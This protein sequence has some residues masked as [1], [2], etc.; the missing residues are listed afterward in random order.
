MAENIAVKTI[1]FLIGFFILLIAAEMISG[2]ILLFLIPSLG[3]ATTEAQFM[4]YLRIGVY[5]F[6]AIIL[7]AAFFIRKMAAIGFLSA[8][9]FDI[10]FGFTLSSYLG[11]GTN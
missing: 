6:K 7:L 10:L 8:E 3:I 11:I 4:A 1:E 2:I 5:T 9:I